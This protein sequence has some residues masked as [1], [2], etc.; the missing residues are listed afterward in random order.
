MIANSILQ[1]GSLQRDPGILLAM[2]LLWLV[3]SKARGREDAMHAIINLDDWYDNL[4]R[5]CDDGSVQL[6][7]TFDKCALDLINF[8]VHNGACFLKLIYKD[9]LL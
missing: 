1:R 5:N 7:R 8:Y 6:G 9:R 2:T 4:V 3:I